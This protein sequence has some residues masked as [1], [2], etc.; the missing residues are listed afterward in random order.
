[1]ARI[2]RACQELPGQH[3]FEYRDD[4]GTVRAIGSGDVNDY[5]REVTGK[6]ITAKDFRTWRGTL[7]AALGFAAHVQNGERP[8][9]AAVRRVLEQAADALGNTVTVCR[10]CYVHPLVLEAFLSG[11]FELRVRPGGRGR[12]V[13]K[14]EEKAVLAF[15]K[16]QSGN[17]TTSFRDLAKDPQ[18]SRTES[19]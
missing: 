12:F 19:Q 3:L 7:E 17:R 15:L 13:L 8:S 1:M 18:G 9:K 6:D 10:K 4:D 2:I 14:P 5:L 16:S 11:S